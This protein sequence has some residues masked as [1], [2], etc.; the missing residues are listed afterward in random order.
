MTIFIWFGKQL[1]GTCVNLATTTW[2][3]TST[4]LKSRQLATCETICSSCKSGKVRKLEQ[5][6]FFVIRGVEDL[7][8]PKEV[9]TY[10]GNTCSPPQASGSIYCAFGEGTMVKDRNGT[11]IYVQIR[12]TVHATN[13]EWVLYLFAAAIFTRSH[14]L[15]ERWFSRSCSVI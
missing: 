4:P 15:A 13:T 7:T 5:L 9:R 2:F 10:S 1:P 11:H 8:P 12:G 3:E 14:A 6:P